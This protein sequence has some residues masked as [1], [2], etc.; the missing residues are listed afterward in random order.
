MIWPIPVLVKFMNSN[1]IDFHFMVATDLCDFI[2]E[3]DL[4]MFAIALCD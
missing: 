2:L 1:L 3:L 4:H